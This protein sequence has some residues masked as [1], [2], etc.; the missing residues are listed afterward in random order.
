MN[1]PV[2]SIIIPLYNAESSIEA[3]LKSVLSQ[4][5]CDKE[6]I[7]VNDGSTDRTPVICE[8]YVK[9]Y[10]CVKAI[11][12][13]NLGASE[14]RNAGIEAAAGEWISFVDADD[15]VLPGYLAEFDKEPNKTDL[16]YFGSYFKTEDACDAIY[17]LPYKVY[18]G[19]KEIECAILMLKKNTVGYEHYG[20]TWNKFFKSSIIKANNIRFDKDI[21]FR[22]D[23]IFVNDYIAHVNSL[24]TLSHIGYQYNY[25]KGGLSWKKKTKE[26]W[27]RYYEKSREFLQGVSNEELQHYE[28]PKVIKACFNTF[29]SEKNDKKYLAMLN[30]ML[31]LVKYYGSLYPRQG[32]QDYYSSI[33]D[34]YK[35]K[36]AK[37]RIMVLQ[38]KKKLKILM[39][40]S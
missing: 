22:E 21:Y 25:T 26:Y 17:S 24:T 12:Q 29:E 15:I 13:K 14:A 34:Y 11:H 35:S 19:K 37:R 31:G 32:H 6:I 38:I 36:D 4:D 28:Y 2:Y 1:R 33:L 27:Q 23:E 20:Y 18:R 7:L 39:N 16:N 8:K 40:L 10:S 30:E 9:Q 5:V 3:C